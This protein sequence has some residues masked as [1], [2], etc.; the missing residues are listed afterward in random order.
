MRL[1]ADIL[2]DPPRKS[3]DIIRLLENIDSVQVKGS[4]TISDGPFDYWYRLKTMR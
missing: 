1:L 2:A 3:A 4:K